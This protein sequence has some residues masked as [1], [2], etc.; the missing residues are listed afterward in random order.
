VRSGGG[1]LWVYDILSLPSCLLGTRGDT[2]LLSW[3]WAAS[4]VGASTLAG[5]LPQCAPGPHSGEPWGKVSNMVSDLG[6][7][8]GR[9]GGVGVLCG[10][11]LA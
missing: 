2:E 4:G 9:W 5:S 10:V 7:G 11:S 1:T 8:C 6:S 3:G